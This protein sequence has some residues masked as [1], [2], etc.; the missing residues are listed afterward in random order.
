MN[1]A[2]LDEDPRVVE[3]AH[4]SQAAIRL[5]P[6]SQLST[7]LFAERV[8]REGSETAEALEAQDLGVDPGASE[9]STVPE[10]L[11]ARQLKD[12]TVARHMV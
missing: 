6:S 4:A 10:D 2:N 11:G 12:Q 5:A 8:G 3:E 9:A 7:F 1:S